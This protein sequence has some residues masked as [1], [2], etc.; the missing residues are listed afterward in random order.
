[1]RRALL[2][3]ALVAE[4]TTLFILPWWLPHD[5]RHDYVS[6]LGVPGAP[7][8]AAFATL[9]VVAAVS[10]GGFV[11]SFWNARRD[12]ATRTCITLWLAFFVAIAI[13]LAF[14]CDPG[15]ALQTRSARIHYTLG[16]VG[17]TCLG[18]AGLAG[19]WAWRH[20]LPV[21]ATGLALA[22]LDVALLV[23]D[24]TGAYRGI[25]ERAVLLTMMTWSLLWLNALAAP[26]TPATQRH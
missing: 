6:T 11:A 26:G 22:T 8:A 13:G 4:L 25:F 24:V 5:W 18:L 7:T 23:A 2:G 10:H 14:P 12:V 9:G 1:M 15:C 3:T 19:A 17:F 16:F 21:A 20:R